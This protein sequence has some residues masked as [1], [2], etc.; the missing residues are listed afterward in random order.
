MSKEKHKYVVNT[1]R[2]FQVMLWINGK[3]HYIGLYKTQQEATT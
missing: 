1:H 3:N 2:G